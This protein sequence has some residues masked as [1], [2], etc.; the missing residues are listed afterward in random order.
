MQQKHDELSDLVLVCW[1]ARRYEESKWSQSLWSNF[2]SI[3]DPCTLEQSYESKC[4]WSLITI[5]EGV[6]FDDEIE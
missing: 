5:S 2:V 4:S 3:G 6:I 1:I